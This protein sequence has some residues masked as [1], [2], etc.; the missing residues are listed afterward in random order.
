MIVHRC[1]HV[2]VMVTFDFLTVF[3]YSKGLVF[4][5]AALSFR[6]EY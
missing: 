4:R 5:A 3:A 1:E 6:D 2:L